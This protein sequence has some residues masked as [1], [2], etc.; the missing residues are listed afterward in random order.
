MRLTHAEL[1]KYT[2]PF[3][4]HP[5]H[6]LRAKWNPA[7]VLPQKEGWYERK[8][9]NT[10]FPGGW[11]IYIDW[12]DGFSTT[13]NKPCW[14]TQKPYPKN[15]PTRYLSSDYFIFDDNGSELWRPVVDLPHYSIFDSRFWRSFF[16]GPYG[17]VR[18]TTGN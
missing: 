15:S 4:Q 9:I 3:I 6:D 16:H 10:N 18:K 14:Y 17:P 7:S 8:Y 1:L 12:Y 2:E 5:A 13:L 11:G